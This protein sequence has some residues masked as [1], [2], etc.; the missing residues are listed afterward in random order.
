ML[1]VRN[2]ASGSLSSFPREFFTQAEW[3]RVE[4]SLKEYENALL[5]YPDTWSAHYNLGNYL[6]GRGKHL[7]AVNSYEKAIEL[8]KEALLPM[9]NASIAYNVL[10]NNAKAEE[11]LRQALRLDPDNSAVNLNYGLLLA[12][13]QRFEE[14]RS[15]LKHAFKNDSTLS[16]AA[17]NL[18]ILSAQTDLDEAE[19][20]ISKAYAIEPGNPDYAYTYAYYAFENQHHQKAIALLED[21]IKT[22]PDFIDGYLFLANIYEQKNDFNQAIRIYEKAA[23]LKNLPPAHRQNILAR[24]NQL[25]N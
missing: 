1:L 14:A 10:G 19:T 6:Q 3:Q 22:T 23:A 21:L 12:E 15:H 25:K 18:A 8:E 7:E 2:K 24:A 9:V 4:H 5:A 11:K 13:K 20:Y 17:Y 16:Q